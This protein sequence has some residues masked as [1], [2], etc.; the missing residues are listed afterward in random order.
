[1]FGFE[2]VANLDIHGFSNTVTYL[3]IDVP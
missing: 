3:I 2:A 1:M